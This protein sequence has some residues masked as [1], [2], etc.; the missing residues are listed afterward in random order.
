MFTHLSTAPHR[1]RKK[2]ELT[3]AVETL[4]KEY[5]GEGEAHRLLSAPLTLSAN[6]FTSITADEFTV[7]G[8]K[9]ST[10]PYPLLQSLQSL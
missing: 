2:R 7:N 10:T 9:M 6:V 1:S 4:K 8:F 3:R 5:G